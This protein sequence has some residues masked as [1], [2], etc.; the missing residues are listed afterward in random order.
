[1]HWLVHCVRRSTG[2]DL[3]ARRETASPASLASLPVWFQRAHFQ[4]YPTAWIQI[5]APPS[6]SHHRLPQSGTLRRNCLST[7]LVWCEEPLILH[8]SLKSRKQPNKTY[9]GGYLRAEMLPRY[10]SRTIPIQSK[11]DCCCSFSRPAAVKKRK[12]KKKKSHPHD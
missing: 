7:T 12:K 8:G 2:W 6:P 10:R 3:A 1:M 4:R 11:A 9:E 5:L